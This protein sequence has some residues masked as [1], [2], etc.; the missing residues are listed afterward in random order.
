MEENETKGQLRPAMA[1]YRSMK[2][3]ISSAIV[4]WVVQLVVGA[5]TVQAQAVQEG[6]AQSWTS[7]L[8]N[9][10]R[11]AAVRDPH[12]STASV[13][14][15]Y[16]VGAIDDPDGLEGLAHLTEH[17]MFRRTFGV[18]AGFHDYLASLG[19]TSVNGATHPHHTEYC[20]TVPAGA[21]ENVLFAEGERMAFLLDS[22]G[23][24]EVRLEKEIVSRELEQRFPE[25]YTPRLNRV[26]IERLFGRNHLVTR[27]LLIHGNPRRASLAHVQRF[28][29]TYYRPSNAVVSVVSPLPREEVESAIQRYLGFVREHSFSIDRE[30]SSSSTHA[31]SERHLNFYSPMR[32]RFVDW[33]W[34]TPNYHAPGDAELDIVA[35]Y[36]RYVLVH[37]SSWRHEDVVD[38]QVRQHSD[39]AGSYFRIR[40]ELS[41]QAEMERYDQL[42]ELAVRRVI[43][44]PI[45]ADEFL[46]I[47]RELQDAFGVRQDPHRRAAQIAS[48]ML[49]FD[50]QP[51]SGGEAARYANL[52]EEMVGRAAGRYLRPSL[53]MQIFARPGEGP[54]PYV[55]VR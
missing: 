24:E 8:G 42:I 23:Q 54:T 35:A 51:E 20:E 4:F 13:C 2:R 55:E 50:E 38:L 9:G 1:E 10:L 22:I 7:Q 12:I 26:A 39:F 18:G 17:L 15:V 32:A 21:L 40:I 41:E 25:E 31:P 33:V 52:S 43:R 5:G 44:A 16:H 14:V 49:L 47:R 28:F 6:A 36:L 19:A 45:P 48:R 27:K 30:T 29:Q 53:A 34:R 11:I 3:V 37:D 46:Q